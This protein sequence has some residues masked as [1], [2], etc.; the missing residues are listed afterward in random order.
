MI[1]ED[2]KYV[3][4]SMKHSNGYVAK[5]WGND[6]QSKDYEERKEAGYTSDLN[7]CER[8]RKWEL[9]ESRMKNYKWFENMTYEDFIHNKSNIIIKISDLGKVFKIKTICEFI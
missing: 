9:E 2:R 8:W 4:L 1:S 7:K 6:G 5:F 3:I